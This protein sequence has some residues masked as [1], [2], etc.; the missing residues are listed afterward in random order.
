M[1]N[2]KKVSH[3]S[4]P[5]SLFCLPCP[6]GTSV[7]LRVLCSTQDPSL[8]TTCCWPPF[9]YSCKLKLV[10]A[11]DPF[12]YYF[13][14]FSIYLSGSQILSVWFSSSTLDYSITQA[15]PR[16]IKAESLGVKLRH[17]YFQKVIWT[18]NQDWAPMLNQVIPIG[19]WCCQPLTSV[20]LRLQGSLD[21]V[22]F[23]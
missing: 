15:Y 17:W 20:Q 12:P 9:G 10:F 16:P 4:Q 5:V 1:K 19:S 23:S 7:V 13:L 11:L 3:K 8:E 2:P 6:A 21:S 18:Y 14:K 22:E